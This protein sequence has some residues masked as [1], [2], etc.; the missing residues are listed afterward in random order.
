[1]EAY[2]SIRHTEKF[3]AQIL[4][5]KQSG[6][7]E[8]DLVKIYKLGHSTISRWEDENKKAQFE[9]QASQLPLSDIQLK[10]KRIDELEFEVEGL[11]GELNILKA[12]VSLLIKKK[13]LR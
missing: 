13:E 12:A 7:K 4:K 10:E 6:Q 3:K 11:K 5:L 2:M 8:R 1:M 9:A